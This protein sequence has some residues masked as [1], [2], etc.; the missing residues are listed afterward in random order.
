M[1]RFITEQ[2]DERGGRRFIMTGA[3]PNVVIRLLISAHRNGKLK[4]TSVKA[5]HKCK[6]HAAGLYLS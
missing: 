1:R 6:Q 5:D 2:R 3:A 4:I